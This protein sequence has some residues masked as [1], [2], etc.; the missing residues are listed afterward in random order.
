MWQKREMEVSLVEERP[1]LNLSEYTS[2]LSGSEERRE[3]R[4]GRKAQQ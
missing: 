3:T 2:F 1:P 4:K